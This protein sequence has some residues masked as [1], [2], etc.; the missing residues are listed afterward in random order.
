MFSC[1]I[2]RCHTYA[3]S[4]MLSLS[5]THIISVGVR[6]EGLRHLPAQEHDRDS[7]P[8]VQASARPGAVRA[9]GLREDRARAAA[10]DPDVRD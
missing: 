10:E 6:A 7:C 1:L 3:D 9:A 4:R 5:H 8:H 2:Y